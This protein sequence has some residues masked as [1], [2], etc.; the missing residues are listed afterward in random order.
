VGSNI[1]EYDESNLFI[2]VKK[3][4]CSN[5]EISKNIIYRNPMNHMTVG[6]KKSV[7]L[8]VG[9]YPN[10]FL[11]GD[12]GLWIKLKAKG[13]NFINI[14]KSLVKATTGRRMIKDRGGFRYVIS[15]FLLQKYLYSFGLTNV[16]SAFLIFI[17]RSFIFLL[18]IVLRQKIYLMFLRN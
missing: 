17:A 15:E 10:L 18:P 11:K 8:S 2:S 6:Y 7:I 3:V 12:Y 13:F 1:D 16:L 14:N 9:G 4:P 5:S